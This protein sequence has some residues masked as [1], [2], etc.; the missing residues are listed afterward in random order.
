VKGEQFTR[1]ERLTSQD[2]RFNS[3]EESSIFESQSQV[4]KISVLIDLKA[5]QTFLIATNGTVQLTTNSG[6]GKGIF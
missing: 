6:K 2:Q 3:T 5:S 1:R 4:W